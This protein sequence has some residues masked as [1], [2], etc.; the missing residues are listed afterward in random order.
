MQETH[1]VKVD[2]CKQS[3]ENFRNDIKH[4]ININGEAEA[5]TMFVYCQSFK[6]CITHGVPLTEE[7]YQEAFKMLDA[8]RS[9]NGAP[10]FI[11]AGIH[12]DFSEAFTSFKEKQENDMTVPEGREK[13]KDIT[14]ESLAHFDV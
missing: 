5:G 8:L 1:T 2:E 13:H 3:L 10:W 11:L 7:D 12:A 14:A 4:E 9:I 6:E